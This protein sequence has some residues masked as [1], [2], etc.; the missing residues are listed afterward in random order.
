MIP[1][2]APLAL[3][4]LAPFA[5][6][7]QVPLQR[8]DVTTAQSAAY[9]P[10]ATVRIEGTAGELNIE[11]WDEPRVEATLTRSEYTG[12]AKKDNTK[13][14]LAQI[15]VAVEK[16]GND[17]AVTMKFPSRHFL[18][19]WFRGK[20]NANIVC[21]VMIPRDAKLL[22]RHQNGSLTT[23]GVVSDID[24]KVHYGDIVLQ[25][26]DPAPYN[27]QT[28]VNMGGVFSDYAGKQQRKVLVGRSYAAQTGTGH[29]ITAHVDIGG[30]TL[31]K[32]FPQSTTAGY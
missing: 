13:K 20:T 7:A 19:R 11:A 27:F 15:G 2:L 32:M 21:R 29:K 17:I 14:K 26:P 31:V 9:T 10:G 28:R 8:V 1:R 12:P 23:Y 5:I 4:V 16:S 25:L 30:I 24:A 18:G 6:E 22:V 3:L